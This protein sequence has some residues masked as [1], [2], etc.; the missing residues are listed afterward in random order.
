MGRNVDRWEQ[1]GRIFEEALDRE[2]AT[3]RTFVTEACAGDA[4]LQNEVASL[5]RAHEQAGSFM[6]WPF[7]AKD[8]A[9]SWRAGGRA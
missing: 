9:T 2:P 5:L 4:D 1:I 3:R 6:E 7:V 8:G